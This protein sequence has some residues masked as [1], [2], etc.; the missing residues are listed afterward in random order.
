M[1]L[2][3]L[4]GETSPC[5]SSYRIGKLGFLLH[6]HAVSRLLGREPRDFLFL[7]YHI[8]GATRAQKLVLRIL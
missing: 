2:I 6:T 5:A 1:Y 4:P 7:P 8:H 3:F